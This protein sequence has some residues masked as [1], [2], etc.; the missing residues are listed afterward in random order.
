MSAKL[1]LPGIVES[2][3]ARTAVVLPAFGG[4][5]LELKVTLGERVAKGQ[6]LLVID[7]PDL[8]QAYDDNDRAAMPLILPKNSLARKKNNSRTVRLRIRTWTRPRATFAK[9]RPSTFE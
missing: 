2:D 9:P 4:R 6:A 5:V 1:T 8:A 3:P 7:S